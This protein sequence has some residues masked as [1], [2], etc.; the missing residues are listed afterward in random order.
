MRASLQG[1]FVDQ[2]RSRSFP[3]VIHFVDINHS[4]SR[5]QRSKMRLIVQ[6][7]H[8]ESGQVYIFKTLKQ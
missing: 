2:R 7:F 3:V 4:R 5:I 1:I 8:V 6:E